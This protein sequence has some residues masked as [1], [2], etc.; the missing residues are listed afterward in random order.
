[1]GG[2]PSG[3][4]CTEVHGRSVRL[5]KALRSA[6]WDVRVPCPTLGGAR[7]L[8]RGVGFDCIVCSNRAHHKSS[9]AR[10]MAIVSAASRDEHGCT[11]ASGRLAA[12]SERNRTVWE[13]TS[14]T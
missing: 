10:R 14:A 2:A 6:K 11:H 4:L 1:M 9:V 13:S 7:R 8:S 5:T 3:A 12:K